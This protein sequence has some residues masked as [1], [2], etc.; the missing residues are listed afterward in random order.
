M[1]RKII[2]LTGK[3][4]GRLT[5][6]SLDGSMHK[7]S[8]WQCLCDCGKMTVV[9]AFSLKSGCTK[10]CGCLHKEIISKPRGVNEDTKSKE[11]RAWAGMK[12]RCYLTSS[13]GFKYWG[14]RGIKVCDRWLHSY[15]N[16][17]SDMGRAPSKKHT[18][19]RKDNNKNYGPD[20][21][22]W[23]T[24]KEQAQN[25][26]GTISVNGVSLFDYCSSNNLPYS[27][28]VN[29]IRRGWSINDA[30]NIPKLLH[31]FDVNRTL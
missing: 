27:R 24:M 15:K 23:A 14:G 16:F 11:Y 7:Q 3:V 31:R 17:L 25:R 12:T 18:L 5:V 30:I 22:K 28:V 29:R 19:E 8:R 21:C 26:R 4:Y 1:G 2:D 9:Y 20:N 6:I 13:V 10:S